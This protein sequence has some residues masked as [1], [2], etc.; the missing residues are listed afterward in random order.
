MEARI[1]FDSHR[2]AARD[3]NIEFLLSKGCSIEHIAVRLGMSR[4]AL[5]QHMKR[6]RDRAQPHPDSAA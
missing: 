6:R 2:Q 5:D 1:D 4:A 3:E